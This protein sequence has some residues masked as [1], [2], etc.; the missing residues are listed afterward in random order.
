MTVDPAPAISPD[1]KNRHFK[2]EKTLSM[3]IDEEDITESMT[4]SK[5]KSRFYQYSHKNETLAE[6]YVSEKIIPKASFK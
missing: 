3:P 1:K 4:A 5:E 2:M 6:K